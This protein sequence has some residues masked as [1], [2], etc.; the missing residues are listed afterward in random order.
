MFWKRNHSQDLGRELRASRPEP[1]AEFVSSLEQELRDAR[2]R[3]SRRAMPGFRLGLAAGTTAILLGTVTVAGG[4]AAASSSVRH[5]F[6][7]VAQ[8]VHIGSP[9]SGERSTSPAQDQ[10]GRKKSCT[11]AAAARRDAATRAASVTLRKELAAARSAYGKSVASANKRFAAAKSAT[12]KL[13][14]AKQRAALRAAS[15][16]YRQQRA[17]AFKHH[18][19][20]VGKAKSRY[21]RDFAS[22][23]IT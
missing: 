9:A 3:S 8:V 2:R 1:P 10:Y 5:A 12:P 18:T 20:A 6:T 13:A 7:Q 4:M 19:Q 21:K 14:A 17:A 11:K 16:K 22:C 23:P 15:A